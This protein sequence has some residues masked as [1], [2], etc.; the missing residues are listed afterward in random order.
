MAEEGKHLRTSDHYFA[1]YLKVAGV[2]F[3]EAERDGSRVHFVFEYPEGFRDLKNQYYS[4]KAKVPALTYADEIRTMK[5]LTHA[6][7]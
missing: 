6:E 5:Y 2:V 3:I 4:R 7:D 1:A